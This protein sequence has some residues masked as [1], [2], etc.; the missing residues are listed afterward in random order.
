MDGTRLIDMP[1]ELQPDHAAVMSYPRMTVAP[2]QRRNVDLDRLY[3]LD[4]GGRLWRGDTLLS[5]DPG[6]AWDNHLRSIG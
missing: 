5:Q 3:A 2:E 1:W 4:T 6:V